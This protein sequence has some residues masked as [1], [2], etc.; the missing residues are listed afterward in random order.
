MAKKKI[1]IFIGSSIVEFKEERMELENFIHRLSN[2]FEDRY[3]TRVIPVV[4][5][6]FDPAMARTRKQDDYLESMRGCEMC[7]FLFYT[8]AGEYTIEEFREAYQTFLDKGAPKV[9]VYFKELG[10]DEK[11]EPSLTE[12][13][14]EVDK[15][16]KHFY[17]MFSHLDTVKLRILLGIK[18]NAMDYLPIEVEGNACK[19]G[20]HTLEGVDLRNVPEYANS[21]ELAVFGRQLKE[22]EEIYLRMKGQY[23]AQKGDEAFYREYAQ[24]AAHYHQL[25]KTVADLRSDLFELML[26]LDSTFT[27]GEITPRMKEAYRLLE[28]GD[29]EG[30][31]RILND[32]ERK[33]DYYDRKERLKA[34]KARID[35]QLKREAIGFI[36]ERKL[37]IDVLETMY[38]YDKRHEAMD[39]LYREIVEE[40]EEFNVEQDIFYD[41]AGFLWEQKRFQEAISYAEQLQALYES[42][43]IEATEQDTAEF[44]NLLGILY[45]ETSNFAKAEEC[46]TKALEIRKRLAETNPGA[47]EPDLAASYNNLGNLYR[48]TNNLAKAEECYT[49]ALEIRKRLAET[50]PGAFEPDLAASYNNLGNLYRKTNNLAKAEEC[51]TKAL[52]IRKRLAEADPGAFEPDLAASYNNL[53]ILYYKT[54][55]FAKAEECHTNALKIRKRL[56]ETNPE[57]FEPD[58]AKSYNNLGNLYSET[59]NFAKAEEY[60][61]KALEIRNRL[62]KINPEA[63]GPYLAASYNNLGVLYSGT[64]NFAKAEEYFTKSLEIY[65]RLAKINPEAFEPDLA[66]SYNNLGLLYRKTNDFAK[67]EEC[68]TKALE[69]RK[70]LEKT[71]PGAF[72]PDLAMSYNNLGILYYKTND[73]AKAEE[74]FTKDLEIRKR[75]AKTNPGAF[76]PDLAAS[77]INLGIL[78]YEANNFVKSEEYCINALALYQR[79][80]ETNPKA[81]EPGLAISYSNLG[82]LYYNMSKSKEAA[83]YYEKALELYERMEARTP[84]QYSENLQECREMLEK[85]KE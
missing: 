49:K 74:C 55:N 84:G 19:V 8:R 7:F 4:C 15:T 71:N 26:K 44:L 63:F 12:F 6:A 37:A 33:Q 25:K 66:N 34:E 36:R 59:S 38:L 9:Y 32:E 29:K 17:N 70:R 69:I 18:L 78:N 24:V 75:L 21:K 43:K 10:Q 79:L 20:G 11:I 1:C 22:T 13:M 16:Y 61:T 62:A 35:E 53:G 60:F 82:E 46:Y 30:C 47:F 40:A 73:F 81:F 85:L 41:Y 27:S 14:A 58:L 42:G 3:D 2:D 65:Q 80:A 51:Y 31:I 23:D 83:E 68:Y 52:E 5:E 28:A 72:E 50:N 45:S 39:E 54:N 57:A 64:N 67:A 56:A 77:Y 76:E 48:K